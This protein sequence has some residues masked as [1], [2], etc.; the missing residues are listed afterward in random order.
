MTEDHDEKLA[1][2]WYDRKTAMM[3]SALGEEHDPIVGKLK[4]F[5]QR[6]DDA[7]TALDAD[8]HSIAKSYLPQLMTLSKK[9]E[10][11]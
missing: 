5:A 9:M 1:Q 8:E 6:M 4:W 2:D 3:V 11:S 7:L 10:A